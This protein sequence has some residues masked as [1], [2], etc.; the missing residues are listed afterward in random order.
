VYESI[1]Y[2]WRYHSIM[3]LHAHIS[4]GGWT[5]GKLWPQ[6]RDARTSCRKTKQA[7]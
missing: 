2:P 1:L 7:V 6:F 3:F 4:H 5:I